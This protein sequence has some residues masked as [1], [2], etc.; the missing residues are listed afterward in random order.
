MSKLALRAAGFRTYEDNK[1]EFNLKANN[2]D[3]REGQAGSVR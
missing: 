2:P 1:P 3:A